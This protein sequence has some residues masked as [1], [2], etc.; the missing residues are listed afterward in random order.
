[1]PFSNITV[2]CEQCIIIIM[3]ETLRQVLDLFYT[4]YLDS[5]AHIDG[6]FWYIVWLAS[7]HCIL[8][9]RP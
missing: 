2:I 5:G 8:E 9:S 6:A 3:I 1:M 7:S 4:H